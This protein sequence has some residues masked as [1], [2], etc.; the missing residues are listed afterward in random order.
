MDAKL[1]HIHDLYDQKEYLKS[2]GLI[3][4]I[5]KEKEILSCV[6]DKK[7][8]ISLYIIGHITYYGKYVNK[9]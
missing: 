6:Q 8:G 5:L 3:A 2:H 1:N 7:D 9:L 4:S